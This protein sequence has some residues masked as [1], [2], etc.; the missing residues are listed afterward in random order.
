[1]T[2]GDFVRSAR[3]DAATAGRA[4]GA[5]VGERIRG[6]IAATR[7]AVGSNTNLGIVLMCAP[8]A[9][10]AERE[11]ADL[12]GALA[13]VLDDLDVADAD[14]RFEAIVLASPGR[15]RRG[16]RARRARARDRDA[17]RGDGGR[18]RTATASP[19]N[20]RTASPTFSTSAMPALATPRAA[21]WDDWLWATPRCYFAFLAAFPDT[22]HLPQARRRRGRSRAPDARARFDAPAATAE[23]PERLLA[24]LLGLGPRR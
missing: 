11:P 6:A 2:V 12:R 9:A 20:Y 18:R 21:R 8:L 14:R 22:P 17:A 15:A 19:G 7:A 13:R 1:M 4:P 16:R 10:A 3:G 24:D 23:E 5:R